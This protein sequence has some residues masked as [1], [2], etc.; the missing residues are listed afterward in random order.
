MARG[1][2]PKSTNWSTQNGTRQHTQI[3]PLKSPIASSQKKTLCFVHL[4]GGPYMEIPF[5]T[6]TG[7]RQD[8]TYTVPPP[9]VHAET[10]RSS[11][12]HRIVLGL[13]CGVQVGPHMSKAIS[14]YS[15]CRHFKSCKKTSQHLD[16]NSRNSRT[17]AIQK[18]KGTET[19]Q[20]RSLLCY[21]TQGSLLDPTRGRW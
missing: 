9:I 18:K 3:I 4:L 1:N 6:V 20:K 12:S 14:G 8:S 5:L 11:P 10:P 21:L 15:T 7:I 16:V 13:R 2:P 17:E 19:N